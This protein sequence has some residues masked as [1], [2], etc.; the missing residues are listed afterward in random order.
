M[1][2]D[3]QLEVILSVLR[4]EL[5]NSVNAVKITLDILQEN[6]DQF[7]DQ[8]KRVYLERGS[9]LLERQNALVNALKSY[10]KFNALAAT[11]IAV[12]PLWERFVKE[13]RSLA[14]QHQV[15]LSIETQPDPMDIMGDSLALRKTLNFVLE[16]A[17]EAVSQGD[18]ARIQLIANS[19]ADGLVLTIID[20]GIGM[21]ADKLS[22]AAIPLFT[23]KPGKMGMGLPIA[24]KLLGEMGGE[25]EIDS[26]PAEGTRVRIWLPKIKHD[27]AKS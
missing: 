9:A 20:N 15:E 5:G 22:K 4:H 13:A 6:F 2:H 23:T 12:L 26:T 21:D 19:R 18:T 25:M 3:D 7:D 14:A 1:K 11:R 17:L 8:K 24:A 16:N 10:S 27:S